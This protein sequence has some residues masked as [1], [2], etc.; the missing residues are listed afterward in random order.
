ML[1]LYI[2]WPFCVSKCPYCDFNSH[3]REGVDAQAWRQALLAELDHMAA[4]MPGETLT[5]IF[6][7]GGTPSLMPPA[8]AGAL[9]ERAGELFTWADDIE[10]TLEANPTTVEAQRFRDFRTAGINRLSLG[11]QSLREDQLKFLGRAHGV[12]EALNAVELA[13]STFDRYSFDLI[14]ARPNQTAA[15]W[16]LELNE[17]LRYA[18]GH[19][20]LY[21][22][23]IEPNTAFHHAYHH[24]G[25]FTLP[26]EELAAD[27]FQLTQDVMAAAGLPAYEISN[28][29]KPGQAS[30]H[31]LAY[32]QGLSYLGV[33][34][35]AHGRVLQD[36]TWYA[37]HTLKSPERWLE[38]AQSDGHGIEEKLAL[39]PQERAEERLMMGL[40]LTEGVALDEALHSVVNDRA[41][42][43]MQELG[44]VAHNTDRI[45]ATPQG[46][47][48]LNQV[49]AELLT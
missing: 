15:E 39:S 16:E 49:I 17:A 9:I 7:G 1:A 47:L 26:Q 12:K 20:S 30:R 35:G 32:W 8:T 18:D 45:T 5:S 36:G 41:L 23:T 31:N 14:Y 38:R 22:L 46:M 34:P 2:H 43:R 48:V 24:K 13:A 3:V 19:L 4:W 42:T 21:Q 25:A 10:I 6:F 40:R 28:H 37:T 11:V 33:G 29:A 27:L 44:L